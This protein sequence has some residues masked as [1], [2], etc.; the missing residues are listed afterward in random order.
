MAAGGAT[1]VGKVVSALPAGGYV[2]EGTNPG[3][4]YKTD[5]GLSF[6]EMG[7][8]MPEVPEV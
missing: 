5:S 1:G 4:N 6:V 3:Q 2:G 8:L 7:D